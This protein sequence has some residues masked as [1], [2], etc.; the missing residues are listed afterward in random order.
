MNYVVVIP[1]LNEREA[2]GRVIEEIASSGIPLE[3]IIVVDGGSTDGTCEEAERLGVK[4]MLQEGKG[5]S[6]AIR[7]I[8]RRVDADIYVFL[9][10]DWTYPAKHI[11]ELLKLA[12]ECDEVIGARK[13]VEPGAQRL[14]YRL[15]NWALTRAFNLI[16]GTRLTDVLSGMYAVRRDAVIDAE[17]NTK[18]FSVEAEVAAHVASTG[19][20]ICEIPI[21]YRRRLG[22]KKLKPLHGVQ[23]FKDMI[24]LAWRY[25][26]VFLIFTAAASLLVPG[27]SLG[28]WVLYEWIFFDVKHYVW[29]LVAFI[30]STSGVVSAA[31]A[32]M[33][34]YLKRMEI[35]LLRAIRRDRRPCG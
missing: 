19:R 32:L 35:R 12:E 6:D 3:R 18:G 34:V 13:N 25:N 16:F 26:P 28:I 15:G 4:C 21:T 23:I 17:F 7:T 1:T 10:G 9:D 30:L 29:G 20:T 11:P 14:I 27:L 8:V 31:L 5:K 33:A 24:L 2:I 22:K